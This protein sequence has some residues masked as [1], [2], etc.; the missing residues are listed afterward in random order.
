MLSPLLIHI[1]A[2]VPE[3]LPVRGS[4]GAS[5]YDLHAD[6]GTSRILNPGERWIISTGIRVAI[7]TG[8]EGQVRGRSGLAAHHG[9]VCPVG[10]IDSDYRGELKVILINTS[11]EAYT[12]HPRDRIA[13]L[14]ISPILEIEWYACTEEALLSFDSSMRGT[15]GLGSTGR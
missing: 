7:P 6:L 14:V 10:T 8:F 13:Q 4:P 12:V 9:I 11:R 15:G 3:L 5:G 1:V 2:R